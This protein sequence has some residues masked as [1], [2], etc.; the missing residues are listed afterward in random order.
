MRFQELTSDAV[1]W[2]KEWLVIERYFSL[3]KSV[4]SHDLAEA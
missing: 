4:F 3:V 1:S 2:K